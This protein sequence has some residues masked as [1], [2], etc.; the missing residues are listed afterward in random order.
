MANSAVAWFDKGNAFLLMGRDKDAIKCYDKVIKIEP[1]RASVW[2]RKGHALMLLG[3]YK[4]AI[5]C[6]N[7]SI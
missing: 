4:D 1:N 7:K 5:E 2:A 6:F 3:K